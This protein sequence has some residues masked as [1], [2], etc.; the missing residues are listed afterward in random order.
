MIPKYTFR[1]VGIFDARGAIVCRILNHPT[2]AGKGCKF[3]ELEPEDEREQMISPV[4]SH[5]ERYDLIMANAEAKKEEAARISAERQ[6]SYLM[7]L[8]SKMIA[9]A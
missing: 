7:G 3:E 1:R 6:E 4:L 8:H 5:F 2:C 9:I